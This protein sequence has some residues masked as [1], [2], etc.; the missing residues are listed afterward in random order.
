MDGLQFLEKVLPSPEYGTYVAHLINTAGRGYNKGGYGTAADLLGICQWASRVGQTAYYALGAFKGNREDGEEKTTWRR[1]ATMAQAFKTF[2]I[3]IDC[4]EGKPYPTQMDALKAVYL[5]VKAGVFPAPLSVSSGYGLHCYW[6]LTE[7]ISTDEWQTHA[8]GLKI[9]CAKHALLI[10]ESKV[11]DP[12]MVLRPP[13]TLNLKDKG[14]GPQLVQVIRD[15]GPYDTATLLAT[16]GAASSTLI[17]GKPPK[18]PRVI[19]SG[20]SASTS[21]LTDLG[22][23]VGSPDFVPAEADKIVA[24][25]A[26]VRAIVFNHGAKASEPEWYAA[27]G[28]AACCAEPEQVATDWSCGHP[29]YDEETTFSKLAQWKQSVSG[30]TT[31]ERLQALRPMG[32]NGCRYAGTVR[33]PVALGRPEPKPLVAA[34][35]PLTPQPSIEPPHP[36]KRTEAGITMTFDDVATVICGYDLFPSHINYEPKTRCEEAVFYWKKPHRGYVQLSI[37]MSYIFNETVTDLN[38]ALADA[39]LMIASKLNQ[40][41]VGAYMRAYLQSLQKAQP[42]HDLRENFGWS[43]DNTSFLIGRTEISKDADGVVRSRETAVSAELSQSRLDEAL[44]A[45]GDAA[46]WAVWTKLFSHPQLA[47]HGF[48]LGVGFATPLIKFTALNGYILSIVGESGSGKSTMQRFINSIYG[49]PADLELTYKDKQLATVAHMGRMGN[50]PVTIDECTLTDAEDLANLT[51]WATQGRDR[52]RQTDTTA[53]LRWALSIITSSNKSLR[54]KLTSQMPDDDALSMRMIELTFGKS[55]I[56]DDSH[57][58]GRQIAYMLQENYGAVGRQWVSHLVSLGADEIRRRWDQQL[59]TFP[60]KF[61]AVFSGRE[62]FWT[63]AFVLT[64]MALEMAHEI[65]LIKFDPDA[66][67]R[68]ALSQLDTQRKNVSEAVATPYDAIGSFVNSHLRSAVTV[69]YTHDNKPVVPADFL[70][71]TCYI[72]RELFKD[73]RNRVT[74]GFLYID[75]QQLRIWLQKVGYDYKKLVD[76]FESEGVLHKPNEYGKVSMGKHTKYRL[77]QVPVLGLRLT[78]EHFRHMLDV[79]AV[80]ETAA[81][82][83]V[84]ALRG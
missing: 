84:V 48:T 52:K 28:I 34:V 78:H 55:M 21:L 4:G 13:G 12:A 57:D 53:P 64:H 25:C 42:T 69:E 44:T 83:K 17:G 18:P 60:E 58:H 26:Q 35:D 61:G 56:F 46:T 72:R 81:D 9:L 71:D 29:D 15:A 23:A 47:A 66:V 76:H 82:N 80:S 73:V 3:D 33:S 54:D 75:R 70:G 40:S 6:P 39:G 8:N 31:C 16:F 1:K 68:G 74:G 10:D 77:G 20:L 22:A 65:G 51:Y 32:C 2:A 11:S 49:K 24:R 67:V 45:K 50:L 19:S 63:L 27:L 38:N 62:R 79:D 43:D 41:K 36:F 7:E 59:K 5:L 14:K 30:A 37:R